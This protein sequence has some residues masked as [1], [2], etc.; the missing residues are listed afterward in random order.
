K[1][2]R[3]AM[4]QGRPL[5]VGGHMNR[6]FALFL[7]AAMVLGIAAGLAAH[8]WLSAPQVASLTAGLGMITPVF[9]LLI[10]MIIAPLVFSTLVAG[11]AHMEGAAAVGRVGA[12]TIGW[13]IFASLVSLTIGLVMVHL[14]QPGIGLALPADATTQTTQ[15][16]SLSDFVTHLVPRSI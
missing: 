9:L 6:L 11:I 8:E 3:H 1:T 14:F 4:S 12:K 16:L 15:T 10:K 5:P 2:G 13:V 7:V